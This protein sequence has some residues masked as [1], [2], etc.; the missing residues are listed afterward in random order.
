MAGWSLTI[1]ERSPSDQNLR[2]KQ[3][4]QQIECQ[5]RAADLG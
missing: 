2:P 5:V 3:A 1:A 4:I